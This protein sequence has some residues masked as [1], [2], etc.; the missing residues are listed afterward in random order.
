[1]ST[2]G[3]RHRFIVFV[4]RVF[5]RLTFCWFFVQI[6]VCFCVRDLLVELRVVSANINIE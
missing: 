6:R 2:G 3:E 1:M 5:V 4:F